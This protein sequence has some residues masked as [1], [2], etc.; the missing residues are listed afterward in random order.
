[1]KG[2]KMKMIL[3]TF[4]VLFLG[5]LSQEAFAQSKS[6]SVRGTVK[7]ETGEALIGVNIVVKG[8]MQGTNTDLDGNFSI[9]CKENDVLEVS[10]VGYLAQSVDVGIQTII[11]VVMKAD[12]RLDEVVV[13]G[14][15][16]TTK[17]KVT[18]AIDQ[19]SAKAIEDRPVANLSQALQGTASNLTIQQRSFNPNDNQI[20]INIRG[21]STM[22]NN[23]PLVVIDGLVS[24]LN[25]LNKLNPSDID[26]ISVL[27]DAGAS[28]I[29]GSRSANGVIL[30]ST[31]KGKKN[32][33]PTVSFNGMVGLQNP[34]VLFSP[35]EGYQNA[36]M[37]NLSLSNVGMA[38]QFSPEEIR[39]LYTHGDNEWFLNEILKNALQQNYN[40]SVKG[41][42]EN[43][44]YLFSAGYFDQESNFVG[45]DYGLQRINLRSNLSAEYGRF[46]LTSILAF[47]RTDSKN[48]VGSNLIIDAS[49][50]PT[51]YYYKMKTDDGRYL[52]N[53]VLSQYNPLGQ[54]EEGGY[55]K[56]K[57]NYINTNVNV[58]FKII[59][60]L[61]LRGILGA[62]IVSNHRYIRRIQVPFYTSETAT[63]PSTYFNSDRNTEDFNEMSYLLNSQL[64]LDYDRTFGKHHFSGVFGTTNESYTREQNEIRL[65]Y[66]DP[67]LGIPVSDTE[68]DIKGSAVT[69]QRTLKT[70]LSS[71][72]GRFAY[73]FDNKYYAEVSFRYDGSSKF[74]KEKRWGFFPS[75]SLGWR[76]SEEAFMES[77]KRVAGDLKLRSSYGIL[78]NQNIGDYQY[79]DKY[80][81]YT[82]VYGY[83]NETVAGAGIKF[84]NPDLRW[85][86]STAFNIGVDATYFKNALTFSLDYFHK[87][88]SDI[89]IPLVAPSTLGTTMGDYNAGEMVNQGWDFTVSYKLKTGAF[90]H[91]F[92]FNFGDSWNKVTAF[93]GFER[94][95]GDSGGE[96]GR[97]IRVGLPFNSY[98]GYKT[99]GYFKNNLDVEN[100]ARPA[101]L[102]LQPGDV[103]YVDRNSDGVI[104]SKDRFVLGNAFPRYSYGFTYDVT[105]KGFD[106]SMLIQGV[107]KRDMMLRGELIEPFHENYSYVM[108]A[109]QLD[110]W[111]PVNMDARWPRLTANGSPSTTNN[112]HMGSDLMVLKGSYLRL[113]NIQLGYTIPENLTNKIGIQ[114]IRTYV[115]AQNL[116]TF[117]HNSFIDPESSEFNSNMNAGGGNSGR[118][119]PTLRYFGF[120]LDIVF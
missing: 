49:R 73:D 111:T 53:N 54:L 78:G 80:E 52:I 44:S 38:P 4:I 37:R 41:G 32:E 95:T 29:Y 107:G 66:T 88:N 55:N 3:T 101:N 67:D 103:K 22:N 25:G 27:K 112:Y 63:K 71:L 28:A 77:Y 84:G 98:Y 109:H 118:N 11:N 16:T 17:R 42:G 8:T 117:S 50:I 116:L 21:I 97:I 2:L 23:D 14:Y 1:M 64:L 86:K 51:Y 102:E 94:I 75:A 36:T 65:K 24:D 110:F 19:V 106:F 43:T 33:R 82:D 108:Y 83:N 76:I 5:I 104:N 12:N 99:D 15:G 113:K 115:N 69:P 85:E 56:E 114:K 62:D 93:D 92:S 34:K 20:S 58:D 18:G 119:Y 48:N 96:L 35:L 39:D 9:E 100:S 61:K 46:K 47:T 68:V 72:L 6:H 89:L 79:M 59:D 7:S 91:N 57:N 81:I 87:K 45:P 120:G 90:N 10:Y 31:K 26:N 30:V 105:F 60:G 74:K 40:L 70:S 13:I